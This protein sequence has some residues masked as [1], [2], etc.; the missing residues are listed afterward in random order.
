MSDPTVEPFEERELFLVEIIRY[1]NPSLG[2]SIFGI[3]DDLQKI[4]PAMREYNFRRGGK[5]PSIFVTRLPQIN[6]KDPD[7]S[8]ERTRYDL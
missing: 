4:I 7:F 6:P 5:Y 3:F 2:V 1:G 8:P